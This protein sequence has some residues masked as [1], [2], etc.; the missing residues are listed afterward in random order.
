MLGCRWAPEQT[1]ITDPGLFESKLK[2]YLSIM[3]FN[4][5]NLIFFFRYLLCKH[6]KGLYKLMLIDYFDDHD[7]HGDEW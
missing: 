4:N 7:L 1:K 5:K 3:A 2:T 6:C